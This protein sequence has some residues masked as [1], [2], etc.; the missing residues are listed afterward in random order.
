MH[1]RNETRS[2][3][4]SASRIRSTTDGIRCPPFSPD[5]LSQELLGPSLTVVHQPSYKGRAAV[6][7]GREI[8]GSGHPEPAHVYVFVLFAVRN[9][10]PP[11]L[12]PGLWITELVD[13]VVHLLYEV[14]L[15]VQR[16]VAGE[17]VAPVDYIRHRLGFII[18]FLRV[19]LDHPYL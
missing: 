4:L 6:Q 12:R 3:R 7:F 2:C 1:S 10:E 13:Q 18:P 11:L 8:Q 19:Y 15:L 14:D 17:F 5:G 16:E 9:L